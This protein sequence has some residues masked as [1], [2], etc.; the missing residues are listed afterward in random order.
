MRFKRGDQVYNSSQRIF[1]HGVVCG[2]YQRFLQQKDVIFYVV[3]T[4]KGNIFCTEEKDLE[5][6]KNPIKFHRPMA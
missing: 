6:S 5:F 4:L 3:E 1:F 2:Y